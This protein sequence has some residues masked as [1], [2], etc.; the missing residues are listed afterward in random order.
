VKHSLVGVLVPYLHV[1]LSILGLVLLVAAAFVVG[2]V[3]GLV[4]AGVA[5]LLVGFYV[6]REMS[7]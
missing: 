4:A 5:C 7:P 2:L 3:V 6:E 1:V